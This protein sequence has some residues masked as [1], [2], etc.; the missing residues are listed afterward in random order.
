[1]VRAAASM[2]LACLV[3]ASCAGSRLVRLERDLDQIKGELQSVQKRDEELNRRLAELSKENRELKEVI[4]RLGS[5]AF[6]VS[7]RPSVPWRDSGFATAPSGP[8]PGGADAAPKLDGGSQGQET[9]SWGNSSGD[10]VR[11]SDGSDERS[12]SFG[13]EQTPGELYHAAFSNYQNARYH[14]AILQFN[15]FVERYPAHDLA[16]NAYYWIGECWYGLRNFG[17]AI[18]AFEIVAKRFPSGNKVPDSMLKKAYALERSGRKAEA[19]AV[20][21]RLLEKFPGGKVAAKAELKLKQ[22]N[23][24]RS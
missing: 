5:S 7:E 3:L 13:V 12:D 17:R 22:L 21:K 4:A 2:L 23:K 11:L 18:A 1:M 9:V 8:G 19:G 14:E 20:L 16:D 6:E 10:E 24:P 15:V